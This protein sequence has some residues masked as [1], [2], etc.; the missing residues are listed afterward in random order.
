M[1]DLDL[2]LRGILAVQAFAG[3]LLSASF[4]GSIWPERGWPTRVVIA[5]LFGVLVYV[6]AGQVKAYQL[7]VPVDGFTAV[8]IVAYTTLI[9]GQIWFIHERRNR[10]G[11]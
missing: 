11:R 9:G 3:L 8:G 7:G 1:T 4:F 6:L 5:G 10:R 2:T